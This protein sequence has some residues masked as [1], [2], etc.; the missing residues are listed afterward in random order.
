MRFGKHCTKDW[1]SPKPR[2]YSPKTLPYP[3]PSGS[4]F[5]MKSGV[6]ISCKISKGMFSNEYAV[7]ISL[8][9]GESVSLYADKSLVRVVSGDNA[10]LLARDCR[11]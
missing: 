7:E 6:W 2:T 9:T 11:I 3:K 1:S 8:P 5:I 4:I 10:E